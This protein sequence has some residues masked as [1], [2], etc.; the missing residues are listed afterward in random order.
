MTVKL[1]HRAAYLRGEVRVS[2]RRASYVAATEAPIDT[3]YG[4]EVLRM[5]GCDLAGYSKNPVVLD[6]H[7]RGSCRDVVGTGKAR[8]QGRELHVDVTYL[9]DEDGERAWGKVQAG[10]LRAVSVG[11]AI[12]KAKRVRGGQVVEGV[13]GPAVIV[14]KWRLIEVSN[15]PVPA[16]Q[17]AVRRELVRRALKSNRKRN[18]GRKRS[19]QTPEERKRAFI[20]AAPKQLRELAERLH[21]HSRAHDKLTRTWADVLT[22][23]PTWAK[24]AAVDVIRES[25]FASLED[26]R[27]ALIRLRDTR[28]GIACL[29][30]LFG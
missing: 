15:V 23:A 4:P 3:G 13:K 11:Y 21:S 20:Q 26:H 28:N 10:A 22:I 12:L 16:D 24:S 2:S 30:G 29:G 9:D 14:T 18:R 1:A 7:R 25:P 5:S 8:I 19:P 6:S 17:D 27:R